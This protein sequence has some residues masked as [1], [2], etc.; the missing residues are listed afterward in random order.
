MTTM[1]RTI[2]ILLSM[3]LFLTMIPV[4]IA[5]RQNAIVELYSADGYYEDSVSNSISYSYHV[6]LINGDTAAAK[7]INAEIAE[8]YGRVV[9]EA[10]KK[11]ED[12]YSLISS[13]IGWEAYW[14]GD[15][16]FLLITAD[17]PDDSVK[18]GAYGYDFETGE[19]VTNPMLLEQKGI[20]EEEYMENLRE[21]AT[22]LF[23]ELYT[24]IPEG[25]KT[26][27]T[28]DSLLEDTLG[29]LSADQPIILNGHGEIETWVSI[30]K[31]AGAGKYD[32]LIGMDGWNM[33]NIMR[34]IGDDPEGKVSLLLEHAGKSRDIADPWYSGN[35]DQT[36]EDVLEGCTALLEELT[37]KI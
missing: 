14:S 19:R 34:I 3:L 28:H 20:S 11:M 16:L 26:S 37:A 23:E 10:F 31:V 1:K 35:F 9:E 17:L 33:R 8:N 6:P 32:Y 18:F 29:W 24:P 27:I 5:E 36:Y 4:A 15:Q 7:E 21:A 13:R 25:V 2:S 30:A 12:G 22:A